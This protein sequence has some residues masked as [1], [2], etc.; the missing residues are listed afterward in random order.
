[1]LGNAHSLLA[2]ERLADLVRPFK[3]PS[4]NETSLIKKLVL[5]LSFVPQRIPEHRTKRRVLLKTNRK[6]VKMQANCSKV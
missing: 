1:M 5:D 6:E 2:Q 4:Y 3:S